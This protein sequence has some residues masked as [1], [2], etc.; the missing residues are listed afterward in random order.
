M[1]QVLLASLCVFVVA[2]GGGNSSSGDSGGSNIPS[3][4][5]TTFSACGGSVV[6][7]WNVAKVCN[8][9]GLAATYL[10]AM[11]SAC[12][13]ATVDTSQTQATGTVD[14]SANGN[15]SQ[16]VTA[17][18]PISIGWPSACPGGTTCPALAALLLNEGVANAACTTSTSGC[19]CTGTVSFPLNLSGTYTTASNTVTMTATSETGTNSVETD[20][21]CVNGNTLAINYATSSDAGAAPTISYLTK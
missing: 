16:T 15:F 3:T 7:T 4:C 6:G 10:S 13:T 19:D 18:G 12:P 1:K 20:Q 17:A 21:Y 14:Y 5:P 2:C 8:I 11:Y 9:S